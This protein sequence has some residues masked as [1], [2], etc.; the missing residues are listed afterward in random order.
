[1][2]MDKI[3][4]GFSTRRRANFLSWLIRTAEKTKYSHCYIKF[5]SEKYE[6]WLFYQASETTINFMGEDVFLSQSVIIEEYELTLP[7][8]AIK[9]LVKNAIGKVG[10]WYGFLQLFGMM[11]SFF[12]DKW[13]DWQLKNPFADGEATQACSDLLYYDLKD[14]IDFKDFRPEYDGPK[15][16]NEII[17]QVGTKL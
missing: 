8:E 17:S 3:I 4:V 2:N 6:S 12:A 14:Y 9:G 15:K 16:I 7:Q 13:F 5:Y 1:M 11:L 10:M